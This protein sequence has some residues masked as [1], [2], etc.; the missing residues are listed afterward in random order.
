MTAIMFGA[1]TLLQGRVSTAQI[2]YQL[3]EQRT[4]SM[5][6]SLA[7]TIARPAS[8]GDFFSVT[9]H[10][11][12][13]RNTFP[14]IRYIIVR[15]QD[16]KVMAS[17]FEKRSPRSVEI[18]YACPP[19]CSAR[20]HGSA[21]GLILDVSFPVVGLCSTIQIGVLDHMVTHELSTITRLVYRD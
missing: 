7:D 3:L 15:S 12:E 20:T 1:V 6:R 8:V 21:K 19:D 17:T 5:G 10:L 13:A 18:R 2:L 16:G 9:E 11:R 14:E 4:L